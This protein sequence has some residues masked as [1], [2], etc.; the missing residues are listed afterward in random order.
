MIGVNVN[1]E[2]LVVWVVVK[3]LLV[4][5]VILVLVVLVISVLEVW[6]YSR[7]WN[8]LLIVLLMMIGGVFFC[9]EG[10]EK[11]VYCFFYFFDDDVEC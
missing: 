10:V 11:L 7:G 4:N 6:L 2:L 5:K 9:F 3:G 1:C 8:V